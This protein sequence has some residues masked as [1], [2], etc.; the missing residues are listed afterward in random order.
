MTVIA[1]QRIII[2]NALMMHTQ[3]YKYMAKTLTID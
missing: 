2:D 1:Q 3:V